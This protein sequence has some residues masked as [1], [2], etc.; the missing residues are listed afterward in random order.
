MS[1]LCIWG[2]GGFWWPPSCCDHPG[3]QGSWPW[4]LFLLHL[5]SA[6][7]GGVVKM[8]LYSLSKAADPAVLE[9]EHSTLSLLHLA[10][11]VRY[12]GYK[13]KWTWAH[14]PRKCDGLPWI[15]TTASFPSWILQDTGI[16]EKWAPSPLPGTATGK[17]QG[18]RD[19][20]VGSGRA[21]RRGMEELR[22][23]VRVCMQS[24]CQLWSPPAR[25][26]PGSARGVPFSPHCCGDVCRRR[27]H[28]YYRT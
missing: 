15:V 6:A 23:G 18:P 13:G 19:G 14:F 22:G 28:T 20:R 12:G 10:F 4:T 2:G 27:C 17:C 3:C 16:G 26:H 11:A 24:L 1:S 25:A 21:R 5:T 8:A 7:R 9:S